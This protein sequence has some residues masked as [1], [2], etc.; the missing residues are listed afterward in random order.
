MSRE[1]RLRRTMNDVLNARARASTLAAGMAKQPDYDARSWARTALSASTSKRALGAYARPLACVNAIS[2]IWTILRETKTLKSSVTGVNTSFDSAYSLT[3]SA[4]GFLLVFRLSR[5]AVRWWD[6]RTAFGGITAGVR[7]FVDVFL[8]YASGNARREGV[9]DDA[10]A[11]ACAFAAASKAFLR[12]QSDGAV[13]EEFT[14]ILSE[15]DV[16]AMNAATHPPLFAL[17]MC[18]RCVKTA[19]YHSS[20]SSAPSHDPS[21]ALADASVRGELNKQCEFLALQVG[22]LERLRATKIPEIYVIH[23]RTFLMVYLTSMPFV[24]VNRWGWG[25]I[26]AVFAVS[27]AL[28]GIEGAATECEIPFN[29]DHV[30]HLKMDAYVMGCFANVAA[31]LDWNAERERGERVGEV[32][33]SSE[34]EETKIVVDP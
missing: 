34:I 29:A 3:F 26:P 13:R 10:S 20:S 6:C 8:I 31:I 28:L 22:A 4:M 19:F 21:S 7:D 9:A 11:W 12:G 30:N 1:P 2:L 16:R 33:R 24:F 32:I 25:T 23:L 18:R 27:F 17:S 15:E 5:A 14:G